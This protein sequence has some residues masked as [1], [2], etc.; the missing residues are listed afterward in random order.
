MATKTVAFDGTPLAVGDF[1]QVNFDT[2]LKL[3]V[4]VTRL[5]VVL[6]LATILEPGTGRYKQG[7]TMW[8]N[9]KYATAHRAAST[10][11]KLYDSA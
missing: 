3:W 11:P 5:G 6:I 2:N 10:P 1:V 8:I 7:R 9:I 4:M